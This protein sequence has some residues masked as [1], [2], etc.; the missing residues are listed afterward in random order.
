LEALR[1]CDAS[2]DLVL[3]DVRLPD[4]DADVVYQEMH[5]IQ[6]GI[7]VVVWSGYDNSG[8]VEDLLNAGADGF[9]Q[10]PFSNA[11]LIKKVLS[12]LGRRREAIPGSDILR[13]GGDMSG[14]KH[15]RV[16]Q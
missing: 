16:V 10:K 5:K 1:A 13:R 8:P 12:V 3:L 9:L 7:R 11:R 15:L 2:V 14:S 6:P 4:L